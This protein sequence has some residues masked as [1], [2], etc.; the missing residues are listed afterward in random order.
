MS[1]GGSKHDVDA[2]LTEVWPESRILRK[3]EAHWPCLKND[4]AENC[5][6]SEEPAKRVQTRCGGLSSPCDID[7][8]TMGTVE[9]DEKPS[10]G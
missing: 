3:K 10:A 6:T 7:C 5:F 2:I 4:L 8:D 1:V 9:E